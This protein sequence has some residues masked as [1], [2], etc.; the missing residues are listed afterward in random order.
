MTEDDQADF[1]NATCCH[2]C[3]RELQREQQQT[4]GSEITI[5]ERDVIE[6]RLTTSAT[7]ITSRT[8]SS[9]WSSIILKGYNSHLIIKQAHASLTTSSATSKIDAT[10]N[11][12]A[13]KCM[14]FLNRWS[15]VHWLLPIHG[16]MAWEASRKPIRPERQ[17]QRLHIHATKLPT[18]HQTTMPEGLLPLRIG[19]WHQEAGPQRT[20]TEIIILL[21]AETRIHNR[22]QIHT[23]PEGL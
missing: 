20:A 13:N 12:Y 16:V 6:G 23:R 22:G 7:S 3:Q 5:T 11:S 19:Q 17:V 15:Q 21:I 8:G 2:I 14:T 18:T 4:Q 1:E 10:P 9:P